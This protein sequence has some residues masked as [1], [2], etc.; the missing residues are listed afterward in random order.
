MKFTPRKIPTPQNLANVALHYL[1]RFAASEASL[2]RVL[3]NRLR[4]AAL[5][6][7]EFAADDARK[8]G[9]HSTIE[10][11][12]EGH[13]RTGVLND[14]AFAETKVNSLRRQG[15]SRRAIEQKLAVKGI[16]STHVRR[17]LQEHAEG[18]EPEEIELKAALSLA[19]RR[20]LGPYRKGAMSD[21][22]K[23][24]DFAT[25]AR[26]GFSSDIARK[27]LKAEIAEDWD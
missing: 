26:A 9:L 18:A 24:K 2:R 12:I 20:K 3:Q 4:R 22:L 16:A 17:A 27:V 7:P 5:D 19:R 13:K 15:R 25:L 23:R 1:G 11:I 8:A 14:A 21:E 10:T 6:N